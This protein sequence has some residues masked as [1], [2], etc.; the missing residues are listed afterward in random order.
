M[1]QFSYA[2]VMQDAVVDARERER[3]VLDR[4]I[5]LLAEKHRPNQKHRQHHADADHRLAH[6]S[7][8]NAPASTIDL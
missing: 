6:I 5:A 1:Y 8:R 7:P 2:E 3:Q 4:S